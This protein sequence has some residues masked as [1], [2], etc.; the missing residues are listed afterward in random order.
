MSFVDILQF[1][2]PIGAKS[3]ISVCDAFNF[4]KFAALISGKCVTLVFEMFRSIND[5]QLP[6]TLKS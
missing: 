6:N 5:T 3:A 1:Q 2:F 4:S